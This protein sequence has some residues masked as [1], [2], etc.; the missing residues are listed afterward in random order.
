[1]ID[2][3]LILEGLLATLL[4]VIGFLYRQNLS[5][6]RKD[7]YTGSQ[8]LRGAICLI[9]GGIFLMIYGCLKHN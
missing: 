3:E 9:I 8:I 7:N 4:G 2:W 1:M 5:R 6:E